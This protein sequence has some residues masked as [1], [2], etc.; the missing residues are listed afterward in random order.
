VAFETS[1]EALAEIDLA[2]AIA[3][4]RQSEGER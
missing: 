4:A 1:Y 3:A 2:G